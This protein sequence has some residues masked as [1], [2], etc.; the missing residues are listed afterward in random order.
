MTYVAALFLASV[1]SCLKK[2]IYYD[3]VCDLLFFVFLALWK[4]FALFAEFSIFLKTTVP[5]FFNEMKVS[6]KRAI[7][8]D[9]P[10][11]NGCSLNLV[12]KET[13]P[14]TSPSYSFFSQKTDL[15]IRFIVL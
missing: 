3:N 12:K 13:R 5:T 6:I 2:N 1:R 15:I 10:F 7:Y 11:S 8:G 14:Q 9:F 4:I